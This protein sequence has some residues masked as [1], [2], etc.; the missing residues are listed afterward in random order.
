MAKNQAVRVSPLRESELG[1]AVYTPECPTRHRIVFWGEHRIPCLNAS[2]R[3]FAQSLALFIAVLARGEVAPEPDKKL[4]RRISGALH[5]LP[6]CF[7]GK[8]AS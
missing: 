1:E 2:C 3:S 5:W 4:A 7:P 6:S 8:S